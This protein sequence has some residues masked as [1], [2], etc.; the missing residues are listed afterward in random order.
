MYLFTTE[1]HLPQSIHSTIAIGH[2]AEPATALRHIFIRLDR[3]II[4][5]TLDVVIDETVCAMSVVHLPVTSPNTDGTKTIN[6]A[7]ITTTQDH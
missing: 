5:F 1:S 7:T 6:N 2:G 4:D 3:V